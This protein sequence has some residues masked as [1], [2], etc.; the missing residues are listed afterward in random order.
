MLT[1][2][3]ALDGVRGIAITLVMATHFFGASSTFSR[4]GGIGVRLF[5]VLS[6]YLITRVLLR[7]PDQPLSQSARDFYWRRFLR[8]APALYVAISACALFG[9]GNMRQ[10]WWIHGLYLTN[11]RIA[12]A[13]EWGFPAHFW[14]LGVEEQFYL[15][16]FFV[17]MAARGKWLLSWIVVGLAVPIFFRTIA[18]VLSGDL[19][20]ASVMLPG[21]TDFL[22]AGALL[23]YAQ[24]R[25]RALFGKL[26]KALRNGTALL[27]TVVLSVVGV[28]M[29]RSGHLVAVAIMITPSVWVCAAIVLHAAVEKTGSFVA[30]LSWPPLRYVGRISYGL[31]VYH[32]FVPVIMARLGFNAWAL[33]PGKIGVLINVAVLS[34]VSL[35]IAGLSWHFI[36][37]PILS[38]MNAFDLNPF[39]RAA[40]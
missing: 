19:F 14:T 17:V 39:A 37:R 31:Y 1:Y 7:Y 38:L 28:F 20:I 8:L 21:E 40:R 16:W 6:G 2:M 12:I 36:E 30:F 32:A 22:C 15:I 18:T 34:L 33:A 27:A 24:E 5:F 29:E 23:A 11:F 35:I 13:G 26:T 4:F 10:D 3:P 25:D 9:V